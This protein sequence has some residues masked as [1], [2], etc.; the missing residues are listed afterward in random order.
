[1]AQNNKWF[2]SWDG[3]YNSGFRGTKLINNDEE[4][5]EALKMRDSGGDAEFVLYCQGTDNQNLTLCAAGNQWFLYFFPEDNTSCGFQSLGDDTNSNETTLMPAGSNIEVS[6]RTLV[7]SETAL[8][9]A[10]EFM[11]AGEIPRCIEWEEL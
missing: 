1:M 7:T 2:I 9:A 5:A 8:N 11:A 10:R 4:L 3:K 6:N